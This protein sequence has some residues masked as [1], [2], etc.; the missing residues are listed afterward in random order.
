MERGRKQRCTR[1]INGSA[2]II[3]GA[4]R[5][6]VSRKRMLSYK[7]IPPIKRPP[8]DIIS[9]PSLLALPHQVESLR[10]LTGKLRAEN[11]KSALV[12]V[13]SRSYARGF[14]AL[15]NA[16]RIAPP[17]SR[18]HLGQ[19]WG[20]DRPTSGGRWLPRGYRKEDS[21]G[22]NGPVWP[23]PTALLVVF[24]NPSRICCYSTSHLPGSTVAALCGRPSSQAS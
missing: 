17:A 2:Q 19:S 5:D 24:G 18:R 12:S 11:P 23:E 9:L 14:M 3:R 1:N 20:P 21:A 7:N 15:K 10:S 13:Q 6:D 22:Q 16:L 4:N 8:A